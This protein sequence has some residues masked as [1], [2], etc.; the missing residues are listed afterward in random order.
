MIGNEAKA[1]I[2]GTFEPV[3]ELD[4]I[5]IYNKITVVGMRKDPLPIS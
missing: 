3:Q 5:V 1:I 4:A 2:L